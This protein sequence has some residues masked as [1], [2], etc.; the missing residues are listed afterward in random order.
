LTTSADGTGRQVSYM[1][2][3]LS[4]LEGALESGST[5]RPLTVLS[6]RLDLPKSTTSRLVNFLIEQEMLTVVST[7]A[8]GPGPRLFQLAIHTLDKLRETEHLDEVTR[9]LSAVTG[10]SVSIGLLVGDRILLVSRCEP[11]A[12]LRAVARVGDIISPYTSAMGKAILGTSPPEVRERI[13]RHSGAE[14]VAGILADLSKELAEVNARGIA[15]D[16][17]TYVQGLRCRA[18]A[19]TGRR[20]ATVGAISIA[21][22]A[23][24]Y[25]HERAEASVPDLRVS[26]ASL[27]SVISHH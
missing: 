15:V 27:S 25:T 20:G 22:P 1:A 26:A 12:S 24:R 19:I 8:Y 6:E 13:I 11:D 4:V 21:G 16:E 14:D 10:E 5:V 7:G 3:L 23:G 17:E 9:S 18:T 2:R